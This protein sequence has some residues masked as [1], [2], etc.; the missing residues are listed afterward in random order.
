MNFQ[1]LG[2]VIGNGLINMLRPALVKLNAFM[3]S[4]I[5][6]VTAFINAL[7]KIFGWQ[8]EIS[9]VAIVDPM[10]DAAGAAEDMEDATGGAAKNAKKLKDYLLGIDEL[11]VFKP[12]EDSD[13]GGGGGGG[14]AGGG[15]GGASDAGSKAKVRWEKY[16]SPFDNLYD[17]GKAT[18]EA[19]ARAL[20]NVD[21]KAIEA[22]ARQFA[23]NLADFLNGFV[24]TKIFWEALGY[25]IAGAINT[26]VAFANTFLKTFH[27]WNLGEGIATMINKAVHDAHWDEIGETI[28]NAINA[29]SYT[30]TGFAV[31]FDAA[32]LAEGITTAINTAFETWNP[33]DSAAALNSLKDKLFEFIKSAIDGLDWGLIKDKLLEFFSSLDLGTVA[34]LIGGLAFKV[35]GK[36][37]LTKRLFFSLIGGKIGATAVGSNLL[38]LSIPLALTAL[39]TWDIASGNQQSRIDM[40][41][42]KLSA[43][44]TKDEEKVAAEEFAIQVGTS[45]NIDQSNIANQMW[46]IRELKANFSEIS[47][48]D[49]TKAFVGLVDILSPVIDKFKELTKL[50][51]WIKEFDGGN[52]GFVDAFKMVANTL[53]LCV[54]LANGLADPL[55]T[56]GGIVEKLVHEGFELALEKSEKLSEIWDK[57]TGFVEKV[58]QAW[59]DVIQKLSEFGDKL[60]EIFDPG[61]N[62]QNIQSSMIGLLGDGSEIE[63]WFHEHVEP[64]FSKS[65]WEE[66]GANIQS[67]IDTKWTEFQAWWSGTAIV[68]WWNT[69]VAPW[70]TATKWA[71]IAAGIKGGIEIKWT[72]FQTWWSGTAIATWWEN[73]VLPWFGLEQWLLLG[74]NIYDGILTKWEEF[75]AWWRDTAIVQW[76]DNDVA[77]WFALE[78]WT[79]LAINI[80]TSIKTAWDDM[81]KQ[82]KKDIKDWWDNHVE[83][84]LNEENWNKLLESLPKAFGS[85]FADAANRAIDGLNGIISGV[86]NLINSA[87]DKLNEFLDKV[88][89]AAKILPDF[90]ESRLIPSNF[91]HVG[92][93][94]I[95]GF[96]GKYAS[97]GFVNDASLFWAGEN[98]VP[99]ILGTVGGKSAV[100]GG[101]EITGIKAAV[102][103]ASVSIVDGLNSVVSRLE[104]V[105]DA[106][107]DK[108]LTIGDIEIAQANVR[109]SS[110]VGRAI[111]T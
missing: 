101:E 19:I 40:I 78:K 80:K 103:D 53:K 75:A 62:G 76:W 70:F 38:K 26:A 13:G 65:K 98:G 69:D 105:V 24:D 93:V 108:D 42:E 95:P 92:G 63:T 55:R 85:A 71:E 88:R 46:M 66:L 56:V 6:A 79:E 3:N 4:V 91:D 1:A 52:G 9:D 27:W 68:S 14:G 8:V 90:I 67:G 21:W 28:G 17:L 100:A 106:I 16:S 36:G 12:D 43:L 109:G 11:N 89:N 64:W 41:K 5:H 33:K 45:Y 15:G 44:V 104:R 49:L 107:N 20:L 54:L 35:L 31:T 23:K 82:W 50:F 96:V 72:E 73:D 60:G 97:G 25:T 83:K 29:L 94:V 48:W 81:T 59:D 7:G 47:N 2:A 39:I 37:N 77:P 86:V 61:E 57:V 84:Y 58:K 51:K 102:D 74:Q 111:L 87:I 10:E 99:E 18:A 34:L 30:I 22:E 110:R 32:G